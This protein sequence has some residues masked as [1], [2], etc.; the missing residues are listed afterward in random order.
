MASFVYYETDV[1][2]E[3]HGN[4]GYKTKIVNERFVSLH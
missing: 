2:K 1:D 4:Y 3:E